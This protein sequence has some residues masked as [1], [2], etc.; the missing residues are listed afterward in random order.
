MSTRHYFILTA[1]FCHLLLLAQND[2]SPTDNQTFE[3][4][5]ALQIQYALTEKLSL[6]LEAQ[7]RLKSVGDSYNMSFFEAQAQYE[8]QPFLDLGVGYRNSDRLDDVGKKQG[9]EKYNRFFGFAQ[10]KTTFNRFDF[11]FRVQH[12][13]KTQRD[14]TNDSKDN[15][16]WRYKFSSNY[17]IPNWELDPRLSFEFFMLDEFYSAEAYDKFRLSLGSKKKFSKTSSL[18]FKY[19]YEKEVGVIVPASY[20][21]LSLRF[22]YRIAKKEDQ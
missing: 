11:R 8:L 22:E 12:Q 17:N 15:N 1:L 19:L 20:H 7:L 10:A 18:S 13:V 16:R 6:G 2:Q 14:V 5:N 21:I 9:H 4:W 3:S